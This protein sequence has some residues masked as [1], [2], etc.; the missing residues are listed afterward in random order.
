MTAVISCKSLLM[1]NN[2]GGSEPTVIDFSHKGGRMLDLLQ[3]CEEVI[4]YHLL[5]LINEIFSKMSH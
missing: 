5:Y 4:T 3:S 2:Y 1:E